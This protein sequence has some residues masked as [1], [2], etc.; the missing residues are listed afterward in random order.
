MTS[1][2][3]WTIFSWHI[4]VFTRFKAC[5]HV[6]ICL[7]LFLLSSLRTR[8]DIKKTKTFSNMWLD[9][10]KKVC[11][12][13]NLSSPQT[14]SRV[15][16]KSFGFRIALHN[17]DLFLNKWAGNCRCS[18]TFCT[19]CSKTWRPKR[20]SVLTRQQFPVKC[21]L[22]TFHIKETW[23]W[24]M[25]TNTSPVEIALTGKRVPHGFVWGPRWYF[26]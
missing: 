3:T 8:W 9:I 22:H 4:E 17:I 12:S 23:A 18:E 14:A 20:T 11:R 16:P 25:F 2:N 21:G 10:N 15:R 26:H 24:R 13:K 19:D 1:G 7:H 5:R 6:N